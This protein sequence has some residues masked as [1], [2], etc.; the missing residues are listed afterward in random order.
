MKWCFTLW[1]HRF[2]IIWFLKVNRCVHEDIPAPFI[3]VQNYTKK[4]NNTTFWW[5]AVIYH[6]ENSLCMF[7]LPAPPIDT[8]WF[9]LTKKWQ[10]DSK[11]ET[12][13]SQQ[14]DIYQASKLHLSSKKATLLGGRTRS[15]KR[16]TRVNQSTDLGRAIGWP[17]ATTFGY[18]RKADKV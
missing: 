9:I 15:V 1:H 14:S 12:C 10:H 11:Q 4:T 2:N 17:R 7:N 16:L 5:Y 8:S 18:K 3:W 13:L 6:R